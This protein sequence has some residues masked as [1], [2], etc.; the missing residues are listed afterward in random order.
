M[1]Q[2]RLFTH[3]LNAWEDRQN[4]QRE[5]GAAAG[6]V[7]FNVTASVRYPEADATMTPE[8]HLEALRAAGN[9]AAV[10][11]LKEFNIRIRSIAAALLQGSN[12]DQWVACDVEEGVGF[13]LTYADGKKYNVTV[14]EAF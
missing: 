3:E 4:A 11:Y 14:T 1:G 9:A 10:D 12:P 7:K 2:D 6:R 8:K 5:A 13:V